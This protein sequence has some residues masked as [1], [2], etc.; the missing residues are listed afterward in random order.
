MAQGMSASPARSDLGKGQG[1]Q[2]P[3]DPQSEARL[4]R[5]KLQSCQPD[6]LFGGQP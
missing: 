2:Q 5:F 4:Y 1:M 3:E 6:K